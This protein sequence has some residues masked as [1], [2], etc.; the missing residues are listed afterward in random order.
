MQESGERWQRWQLVVRDV[1]VEDQGQ[2]RCQV[3]TQPPMVLTVTLNVTG[4]TTPWQ[5]G[6]RGGSPKHQR[7]NRWH[8]LQ[9][10]RTRASLID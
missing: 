2:Y 5:G 9:K 3:A 4:K 10:G 1:R 7:R 6:A 8:S